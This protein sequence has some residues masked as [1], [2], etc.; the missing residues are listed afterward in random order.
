VQGL[1]NS[2]LI[3]NRYGAIDSAAEY[4]R[5]AA[6]VFDLNKIVLNSKSFLYSYVACNEY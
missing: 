6:L 3:R 4:S 5:K 2:L 1:H